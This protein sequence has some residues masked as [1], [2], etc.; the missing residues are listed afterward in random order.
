MA[1][2][3]EILLL[4]FLITNRTELADLLSL[5][6]IKKP[7][8]NFSKDPMTGFYRDGYCRVGPDDTGNHSVAGASS[9][10]I[11]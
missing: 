9:P 10:A 11:Q 1:Q 2:W 8:Y 3:F 6:V 5:A 4:D 7:L